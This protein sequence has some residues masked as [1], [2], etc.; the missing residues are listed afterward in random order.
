MLER[1][2]S[3]EGVA[4][5]CGSIT[6]PWLH[7]EAGIDAVYCHT[8]CKALKT[9]RITVTRGN[10]EPNAFPACCLLFLKSWS[11]KSNVQETTFGPVSCENAPPRPP[12]YRYRKLL[13]ATTISAN[14]QR[15]IYNAVYSVL[16]ECLEHGRENILKTP[17]VTGIGTGYKQCDRRKGDRPTGS[18]ISVLSGASLQFN[19]LES[20][21]FFVFCACMHACSYCPWL[22]F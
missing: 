14:K 10:W 8:C 5:L 16:K 17:V 20:T 18:F 13:L 6:W 21:P 15:G 2:L 19:F 1:L 12:Y 22:H 3:L 4:R 9:K 7:C 11:M